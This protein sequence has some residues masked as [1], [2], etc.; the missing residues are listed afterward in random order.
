MLVSDSLQV[1][2]FPIGVMKGN[3]AIGDPVKLKLEFDGGR[4]KA[5]KKKFISF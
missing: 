2:E 5:N 1:I 4:A 3:M